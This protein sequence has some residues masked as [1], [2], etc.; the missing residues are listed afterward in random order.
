MI[1][2][3]NDQ[4]SVILTGYGASLCDKKPGEM[5]FSTINE[6]L[7][8][9]GKAIIA[10]EHSVF[11][12]NEIRNL[13]AGIDF[14]KNTQIAIIWSIEDVQGQ[15]ETLTD[16]EAMNVLDVLKDRHDCNYGISWDTIDITIDNLYP[17]GG[18]KE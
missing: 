12:D 6:L 2:N 1:F 16:E 15:N 14:D 5:H 11:K 3:T 13:D 9:F 4:V 18:T 8:T 7:K 17:N 10:G